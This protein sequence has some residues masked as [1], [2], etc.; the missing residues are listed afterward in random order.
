VN[1]RIIAEGEV[2]VVSGNYGIRITRIGR[3]HDDTQIE[4]LDLRSFSEKLR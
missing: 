3:R 1:D 2:V 4:Q